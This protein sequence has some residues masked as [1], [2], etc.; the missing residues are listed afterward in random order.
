MLSIKLINLYSNIF[1]LADYFAILPITTF[2]AIF[3]F[4]FATVISTLFASIA[5]NK[6]KNLVLKTLSLATDNYI[7][8]DS[9]FTLLIYK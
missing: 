8:T 6:Y 4:F 1:A 5:F 3:F 7:S 9:N 2:I